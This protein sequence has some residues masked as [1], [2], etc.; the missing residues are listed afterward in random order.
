MFIRISKIQLQYKYPCFW[1]DLS[2]I[3]I[4]LKNKRILFKQLIIKS[5]KSLINYYWALN[6]KEE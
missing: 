6:L 1:R 3:L 4:L 5:I 2:L